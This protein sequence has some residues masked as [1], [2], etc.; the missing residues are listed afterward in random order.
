MNTVF[1]TFPRTEAPPSFVSDVYNAFHA[2]D[3]HIA[4]ENLDKG[5]T[6][7]QV[8]EIVRPDLVSLGFLVESGK[9]R[10]QKLQRPVFFG[11][12]AVPSL[13]YEVD[14]WHPQWRVGLEVEAGRAKMGNAIYRDL[15]Q[16]LVMVELEYLFLAVPLAYKYKSGGKTVRSKDYEHTVSVA[17]ALYGHS[18]I[19]MP[20]SL[21]VIGY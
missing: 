7:D 20:F 16:A 2:H 11:E 13:Q 21:C 17:E 15:I 4:T 12:N 3:G 9:T 8:L 1:S 14:A 18:R 6:S 5:L 19:V 10:P